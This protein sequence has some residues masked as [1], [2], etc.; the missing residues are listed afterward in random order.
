M[1][2]FGNVITGVWR[3]QNIPSKTSRGLWKFQKL[4]IYCV[5]LEIHCCNHTEL[6]ISS[7]RSCEWNIYKE[8]ASYELV[9]GHMTQYGWTHV[10]IGQ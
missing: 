5:K 8:W 10:Y 7:D 1:W 4:A 2:G 3:N 6:H 9:M